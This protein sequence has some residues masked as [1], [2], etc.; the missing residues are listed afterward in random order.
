MR[1]LHYIKCRLAMLFTAFACFASCSDMKEFSAEDI[2]VSTVLMRVMPE[3]DGIQ[4]KSDMNLTDDET[5]INTLRIYAFTRGQRVGY[6]Y[7]ASPVNRDFLMDIGMLGTD[8]ATGKQ[9]VKFYIIANEE[10]VVTEE[11][12]PALDEYTT[13]RQLN[14]YRFIALEQSKG[15]PMFYADTIMLNT[16]NE[17]SMDTIDHGRIDITGHE[18]HTL[19]ARKLSFLLKRPFGKLTVSAAR[20]SESTPD[21]YIKSIT[22]LAQGTRHYNYMMPQTT[23]VL[24]SLFPRPNDR[25]LLDE[26]TG[27]VVTTT[28]DEGFQQITESYCFE[29]PF[30]SESPEEWNVPNTNNSLVLKTVFSIGEG[31]ELRTVYIYLP[32][33]FR[34][35][36][37][38]V[39]SAISGEGQI[40][41]N[42][43]V[44]D[45]DY[46]MTDDDDDGEEDYIIFDYPTHTYLLPELPSVTNPFPDPDGVVKV[47]PQMSMSKPFVCY[48]Q[49]L[50][51]SG[52]TWKPTVFAGDAPSSDY[53]LA[54]YVND[55]SEPALTDQNGS[56]GI[57]GGEDEFFR[58]ELQ[59]L[60]AR[61]VGS[62]ISLG[63]TSEIQGFGHSEYL[64]I[65]GSQSELFWPAEGGADPNTLIITQTE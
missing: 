51:P 16:R 43:H 41:V 1:M 42:Y 14:D 30:G 36:W 8:V 55:S 25:P 4:M 9:T 15:L 63:I 58:I 44:R 2:R 27:F 22:M 18:N 53:T 62:R 46:D 3:S 19:L 5:V 54:V 49:M 24:E 39:S 45:W 13:E 60:N 28:Q 31:E 29:V 57:N 26:N 34:N 33:V 65:N 6:H 52:Q 59:P 17:A 12:M 64:L 35:Q 56:Y 7:Q 40:R 23:E 50:Y 38:R 10:A 37:I 21:V 32:P 11:D 20:M 48:F 61:N 47:L